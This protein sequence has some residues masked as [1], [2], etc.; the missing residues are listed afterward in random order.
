MFNMKLVNT[1]Q[2][3]C[4]C[5]A[6]NSFHRNNIGL[7]KARKFQLV[8]RPKK[9]SPDPQSH[10]LSILFSLQMKLGVGAGPVAEWLKFA[11]S[12]LSA[13]GYPVWILGADLHTTPQ[14][15]LWRHPTQKNQ[16]D[17]QLGYMTMSWGF[18]EGKKKL[19]AW[20]M[21]NTLSNS[22]PWGSKDAMGFRLIEVFIYL[23]VP[24]EQPNFSYQA[25]RLDS[26]LI[27]S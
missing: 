25:V 18:G 16:N 10:S 11:R 7:S 8:V 6:W 19:A 23:S 21:D 22:V 13:E 20:R 5:V 9:V 12:A 15:V 27:M 3:N 2:N 14:A 24:L 1:I 4:D 17:L 26:I